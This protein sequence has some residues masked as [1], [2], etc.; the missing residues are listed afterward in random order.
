MT[1]VFLTASF[2]A[3][4][5]C[6]QEYNLEGKNVSF[7]VRSGEPSSHYADYVTGAP[8]ADGRYSEAKDDSKTETGSNYVIRN[9]GTE[10]ED[11]AEKG[12]VFN[13]TNTR[14]SGSDVPA[15]GEDAVNNV[16]FTP[17][18]ETH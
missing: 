9:V 10:T 2:L 13:F 16:F 11:K 5:G 6:E 1:V 18:N 7:S 12:T 15:H 3:M 4:D 8:T 17:T 14:R